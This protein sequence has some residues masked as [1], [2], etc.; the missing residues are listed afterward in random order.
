MTQIT[1]LHYISLVK[2]NFK[3]D[4]RIREQASSVLKPYHQTHTP[5]IVVR[6][7]NN[8]LNFDCNK[9]K[10][11]SFILYFKKFKRK[12]VILFKSQF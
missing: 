9:K 3:Q 4:E 10:K 7:I 6:I 1:Q 2:L 12:D 11:I 8:C 5:D